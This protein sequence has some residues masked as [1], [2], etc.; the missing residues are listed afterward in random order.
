MFRRSAPLMFGGCEMQAGV[1]RARVLRE[2]NAAAAK[3]S[4]QSFQCADRAK[5]VLYSTLRVRREVRPSK[6]CTCRGV[7]PGFNRQTLTE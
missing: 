2:S 3:L 6:I 4:V 7:K 5:L 1:D